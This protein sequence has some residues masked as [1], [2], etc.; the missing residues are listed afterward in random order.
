MKICLRHAKVGRIVLV[1]SKVEGHSSSELRVFTV[2]LEA[3]PLAVRNLSD[4]DL[5]FMAVHL[6]LSAELRALGHHAG[7]FGVPKLGRD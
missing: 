5:S 6:P 3:N 2:P 1:W 7:A 4:Q